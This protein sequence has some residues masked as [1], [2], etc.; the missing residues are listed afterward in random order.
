MG[1]GSTVRETPPGDRRRSR[2]AKAS[3]GICGAP[4]SRGPAARKE[5]K[6]AGFRF[7]GRADAVEWIENHH[8]W[9][10]AI[11]CRCSPSLTASAKTLCENCGD[12]I[13]MIAAER[14][15]VRCS[16]MRDTP[17]GQRWRHQRSPLLD[18]P[19]A[20]GQLRAKAAPM[21]GASADV[22]SVYDLRAE[23]DKAD[24]MDS[25]CRCSESGLNHSHN[26]HS[27]DSCLAESEAGISGLEVECV[28][29]SNS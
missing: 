11:R 22:G 7:P 23:I 16:L 17:M 2:H 14:C 28:V 12:R 29:R 13:V 4:P 27:Y 3:S 8:G 18:R 5:R 6:R 25:S 1:K 20:L 26:R 19:A 15:C 21:L 9:R 24:L 10:A